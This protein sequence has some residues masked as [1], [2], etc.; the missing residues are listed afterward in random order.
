MMATMQNIQDRRELK[1]TAIPSSYD[2]G[3]A[4]ALTNE[5]IIDTP[6]IDAMIASDHVV[7]NLPSNAW[8]SQTIFRPT[9]IRTSARP[10]FNKWKRSTASASRKYSERSPRIANTLDVN[11]IRGS[12]VSAKIAGT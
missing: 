5:L 4:L 2:P 6:I 10:Y 11:T 8:F 12:R 7:G 3:Q 1:R 9:K